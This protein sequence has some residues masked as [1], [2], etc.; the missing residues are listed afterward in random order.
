MGAAGELPSIRGGPGDDEGPR[1]VF[2]RAG[3]TV[4][5]ASQTTI[6]VNR[7]VVG[8]PSGRAASITAWCTAAVGTVLILGSTLLSDRLVVPAAMAGLVLVAVGVAAFAVNQMQA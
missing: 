6:E 7:G 2:A 5:P 8:K 1:R 4:I 3:K